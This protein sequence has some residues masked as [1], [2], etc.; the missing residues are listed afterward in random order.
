M[1][2]SFRRAIFTLVLIVILAAIHLY[3]YTQNIDLKYQNTD[4][5]I[6]LNE[7]HS[8]NRLLGSQVAKKEDL[9]QIEKIAKEKL[10]MIYPSKM[11]YIDSQAEKTSSDGGKK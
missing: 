6:E 9:K 2:A 3:V 10:G 7:L 1:K 4:L 11:H 8:K 5:K